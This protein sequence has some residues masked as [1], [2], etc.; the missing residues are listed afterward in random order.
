MQPVLAAGKGKVQVLQG[1]VG[2]GAA[3]CGVRLF[4]PPQYRTAANAA[5]RGT[6][7]HAAL[8]YL[9][10]AR[11]GSEEGLRRELRRLTECGLLTPEQAACADT[12]ALLRFARSALCR[13]ILAAEVCRREFR[14]TLLA[15]AADYFDAPAGEKLLLQGVV[16]C[17]IVEDG[18]IT[19][20]DYKTDRVT[21][22]EVPARAAHYAPQLRA[23]AAALER[24]CALPVRQC[25]LYFLTPGVEY[26]LP[27]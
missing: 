14:F 3:L 2:G 24:I 27:L 23:Y 1:R 15:E 16:D 25:L 26:P 4:L 7:T 17:F 11:T 10:L 18:A 21:P 22:D 9:D 5:Q 19:V 20:I 13:R 8:Q 6:A 12:G